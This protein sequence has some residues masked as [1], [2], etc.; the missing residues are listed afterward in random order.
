MFESAARLLEN[1]E[2]YPT[3]TWLAQIGKHSASEVQDFVELFLQAEYLKE[4]TETV[5]RLATMVSLGNL[6]FDAENVRRL[7]LDGLVSETI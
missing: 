4:G 2:F 3:H 1:N 6:N 5:S 7:C